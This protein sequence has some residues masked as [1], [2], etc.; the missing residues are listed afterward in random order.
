MIR[1]LACAPLSS[2]HARVMACAACISKKVSLGHAGQW[3]WISSCMQFTKV[4][5]CFYFMTHTMLYWVIKK[6][7]TTSY[8]VRRSSTCELRRFSLQGK[9]RRSHQLRELMLSPFTEKDKTVRWGQRWQ[10][11]FWTHKCDVPVVSPHR[12]EDTALHTGTWQ[13]ETYLWMS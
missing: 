11:P 8:G 5:S 6:R 7:K 13:G 1:T 2:W 4:S 3:W 9:G 12:P 10:S